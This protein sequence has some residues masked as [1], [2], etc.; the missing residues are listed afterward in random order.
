MKSKPTHG[1]NRKFHKTTFANNSFN[2]SISPRTLSKLP[3]NIMRAGS[4]GL[5]MQRARKRTECNNIYKLI[6]QYI[7]MKVYIIIPKLSMKI[8]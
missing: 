3:R 1:Y 4:I 6:K 8:A 7:R 5:I 2:N